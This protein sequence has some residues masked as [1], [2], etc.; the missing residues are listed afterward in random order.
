MSLP[1]QDVLKTMIKTKRRAGQ[2]GSH[3]EPSQ[4]KIKRPLNRI[5]AQFG[6]AIFFLSHLPN[7]KN[8]IAWTF[9]NK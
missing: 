6:A 3:D 1:E 7:P 2:L 5:R 9:R 8:N 4:K